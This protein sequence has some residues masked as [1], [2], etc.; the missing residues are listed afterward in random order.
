MKFLATSSAKIK[1]QPNARTKPKFEKLGSVAS[2]IPTTD[3]KIKQT[4][5]VT[6]R[7]PSIIS[8]SHF[9]L[10][11]QYQLIFPKLKLD[12]SFPFYLHHLI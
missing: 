7:K 2:I 8:P 11:V 3:N 12:F 4:H 6:I 10:S 5:F 1:K 9:L